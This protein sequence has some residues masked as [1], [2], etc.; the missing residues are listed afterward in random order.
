MR[1]VPGESGISFVMEGWRAKSCGSTTRISSTFCIQLAVWMV[2]QCFKARRMM[3]WTYIC[4]NMLRRGIIWSIMFGLMRNCAR[5]GIESC[6]FWG[7]SALGLYPIENL[8]SVLV[9][10]RMRM[11]DADVLY[12]L[13]T[14][15]DILSRSCQSLYSI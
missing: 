1:W 3:A 9:Q 2:L 6:H 13:F 11:N 5:D 10:H 8:L 4:N 7:K 15:L 14:H 12:M